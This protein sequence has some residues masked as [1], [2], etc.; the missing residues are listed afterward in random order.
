MKSTSKGNKMKSNEQFNEYPLE[1]IDSIDTNKPLFEG[2][3]ATQADKNRLIAFYTKYSRQP[4]SEADC[5]ATLR[6]YGTNGTV[7]ANLWTA[8]DIKYGVRPL[9]F[10]GL[11][12]TSGDWVR[13]SVFY[14]KYV[15]E[16]TNADVSATLIKYG[17]SAESLEQ[18]WNYLEKKYNKST[19]DIPEEE[20]QA[21]YSAAYIGA[22]SEVE[23]QLRKSKRL[24][25]DPERLLLFSAKYGL[26]ITPESV[27]ENLAKYSQEA[28]GRENMW[29]LLVGIYGPEPEMRD[30]TTELLIHDMLS[31]RGKDTVAQLSALQ[32]VNRQTMCKVSIEYSGA[33][34]SLYHNA[35]QEAQ[36]R[37]KFAAETDLAI[38]LKM[39]PKY[40]YITNV[41]TATSTIDYD[42]EAPVTTPDRMDAKYNALFEG[43]NSSVF[44][45][46]QKLMS[47]IPEVDRDSKEYKRFEKEVL[48]RNNADINDFKDGGRLIGMMWDL[49]DAI[50]MGRLPIIRS[51]VSYSDD[52]HGSAVGVYAKS[53]VINGIYEIENNADQQHGLRSPNSTSITNNNRWINNK[54]IEDSVVGIGTSR[55]QHRVGEY[56]NPSSLTLRHRDNGV[57]N[58]NVNRANFDEFYDAKQSQALADRALRQSRKEGLIFGNVNA[59][60]RNLSNGHPNRD[61]KGSQFLSMS[62]PREKAKYLNSLWQAAEGDGAGPYVGIRNRDCVNNSA[63]TSNNGGTPS[64]RTLHIYSEDYPSNSKLSIYD[65]PVFAPYPPPLSPPQIDR[66]VSHDTDHVSFVR[67]VLAD[68]QRD[69][70]EGSQYRQAVASNHDC[71]DVV[72][73]TGIQY[74]FRK[75]APH[76]PMTSSPQLPAEYDVREY[77]AQ[78]RLIAQQTAR[79]LAAKH[80]QVGISDLRSQDDYN[81]EKM[82]MEIAEMVA[83][84]TAVA[85]FGIKWRPPVPEDRPHTMLNPFMVCGNEHNQDNYYSSVNGSYIQQNEYP[86]QHEQ[87]YQQQQEQVSSPQVSDPRNNNNNNNRMCIVPPGMGGGNFF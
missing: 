51:R 21:L 79:R 44:L 1:S 40:I 33:D 52:L 10:N 25:S 81:R 75:E 82:A 57:S 65:D 11:V 69:V 48:K 14:Q 76:Q 66:E 56:S 72:S 84:D 37:F 26:G 70:D 39:A 7:L 62:S 63:N 83:D 50:H 41:N 34:L 59:A 28:G 53:I 17:K 35:G 64:G 61:K 46:D 43:D 68:M 86:Q 9:V 18:M 49:T 77:D 85:P 2:S 5:D 38:Y 24:L 74:C 45:H 55:L 23:Y 29:K 80:G 4:K 19:S 16:K 78:S 67:S 8:L 27:E 12:V 13:L 73:P 32:S 87:Q 36:R 30:I 20:N 58:D 54:G 22:Q 47:I 31:Q 42:I 3:V 71:R 6:K 60:D 15:P